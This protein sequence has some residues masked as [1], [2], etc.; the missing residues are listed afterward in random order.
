M[1]EINYAEYLAELIKKTIRKY[2]AEV[3]RKLLECPLSGPQG[4]R[5][6]LGEIDREFFAK[7]YFPEYFEHDTPQFHSDAYAELDA[8]LNFPS[9]AAR[10]IR[11]WPRGNAK[12][13]I[14]NFFTPLHS[15]LYAKRMFIVQV[16]DTETQAQTFLTDIKNAI[17]GNA[18]IIEDFGELKGPIWRAD[19]VCINSIVGQPIYIAAVGAG[20][21]IRGLRKAQFRPDL[22]IVDDLEN[23]E[24]V[25]TSERINK[26]HQWFQRA[27]MNLGN[28]RTDVIVVGTII[29]F[30]CVLDRLSK[31]PTWDAK[32]L[33]AIIAWSPSTLWE[34]WKK[35]YTDLSISK[36]ERVRQSDKFY[37]ENE[38]E[39][40]RDTEVLWPDGW[41]Y[42]ALMKIYVDIGDAAF[43][44]E[45]QNEPINF[46][47][48]PFKP[49]WF[50]YYTQEELNNVRITSYYGALDPSLGK[51]RL[52]DFT[53]LVIIGRGTNGFLYV[54]EAIIE[55]MNPDRIL[56][57]L[58]QKG[59]EYSFVRFGI[60][61]NQWQDLL[62]IMF[63]E[64]SAREGLYLPIIELK[65]TKDKVMRVQSLIPYV[66][67]SYIKFSHQHTLL[68]E[69]LKGFP[70]V[71]HDDGPDALEMAVR[72]VNQGPTTEAML[73]G[74]MPKN[75]RYDS[76]DDDDSGMGMRHFF[77]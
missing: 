1:S 5:K 75:D 46:D 7:A 70:K 50:S 38:E 11:I 48:C 28:D 51:S 60:E 54:V 2:P 61:T 30:D 63:I 73:T 29:A 32:K 4:V 35:I 55:R 41:P 25:L 36:E 77:S 71:K 24:S 23:D 15:A 43:H 17:E 69:Q 9:S 66:K 53:A 68:L 62:R 22:I 19:M 34:D 58:L 64:R 6:I 57:L 40:L 37:R 33:Q 42:L 12:S 45:R 13:T 76:D 72:L 26:L 44:A 74:E 59:R 52:S 31:N 65:H 8:L 47:E 21:G 16:S 67:N 14:Y 18:F 49:E 20:S 10:K 27:L 56:E 3:K 39:L